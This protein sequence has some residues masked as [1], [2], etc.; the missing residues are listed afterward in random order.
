MP[1]SQQSKGFIELEWICPNCNSRNR[2]PD[3]ACANCGAPQPENVKFYAP[4]E[5]KLIQDANV[6]KTANV[7]PDIHCPF[8]GTRNPGNA[9]V[10]SQCGGDLTGGHVRQ[11]G[12]EMQRQGPVAKVKC[13]NCGQENPSTL[14]M[15]S[16]CGAALPR[17]G[18]APAMAA[19]ASPSEAKRSVPWLAIGG[20]VAC[21]AAICIGAFMLFAPSKSVTATVDSVYWQTA[22]PVQEVQAVRHNDETGSMPS[23]A[24]DVSCQTDTRQVCEDKT[25]DKGNGYAEVVQECHDESQDYCSYTVNEWT[26]INTFTLDGTDFSPVYA[27]PSFRAN[28]RI[29]NQTVTFTVYFSGDGQTYEYQPGN[30][31]EF[32][33]FTIGSSWTLHLNALGIVVSVE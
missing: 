22:V 31:F 3:K 26:T 8:C 15:C 16:N 2:G 20:V 30:L 24:Y 27:K 12:E 9:T 23:D 14:T 32:Q 28:Q 4:A 5:A 18:V 13:T 1:T 11:S 21:L 33:S 10:C 6:A 17:V 25:I 7:G 19:P 29:G